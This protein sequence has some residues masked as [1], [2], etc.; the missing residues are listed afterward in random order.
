VI[1][2]KIIVQKFD[3]LLL[4]CISS[5][6]IYAIMGYLFWASSIGMLLKHRR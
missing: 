4:R 5:A 1:K 3:M 6:S 2:S